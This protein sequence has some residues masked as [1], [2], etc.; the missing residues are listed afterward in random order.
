[1]NRYCKLILIFGFLFAGIVLLFKK[2]ETVNYI[3]KAYLRM[4]SKVIA[5]DRKTGLEQRKQ[6]FEFE[7][8]KSF[9]L[10]LERELDY[11][12]LKRRYTNVSGAKYLIFNLIIMLG[13][14]VAGWM[15]KHPTVG[16]GMGVGWVAL[17]LL[18]LRIGKA[19]NLKKVSDDLPKFLDFLGNYSISAGEIISIFSQISGYL[20]N[21]LRTVMEECVAESRVSGNSGAALLAMA[22]KIEHP[23]FKQIIRN[24]ELTARYSADFKSLVADS[25]RS[26]REYLSQ[27]RERKGIVREAMI[28]MILLLIMSVVVLMM[29]N[30]LIG[31]NVVEIL[32]FTLVGRLACVGFIAMVGAF[33]IQALAVDK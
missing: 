15:L 21:P 9:W 10:M 16:I 32:L 31:G 11:S 27:V 14:I 19:S 12:G 4:K 23:Q 28:N 17:Q 18:I 26:L 5:H 8:K 33:S 2:C 30:V 29:V 3:R 20:N 24:V 1:M 7:R 25:R 13:A 6:I 22:E